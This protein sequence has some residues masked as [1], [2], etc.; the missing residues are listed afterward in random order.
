MDSAKRAF[1]GAIFAIITA[2]STVV[3]LILRV[4]D[5]LLLMIALPA[6]LFACLIFGMLVAFGLEKIG[7]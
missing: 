7:A 1:F 3:Y 2:I 5:L 4:D 6:S